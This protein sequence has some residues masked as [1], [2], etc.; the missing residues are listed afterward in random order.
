MNC[1]IVDDDELSRSIVEDLVK[2]TDSLN[3]L[4]SCEKRRRSLQC[5]ER[6]AQLIWCF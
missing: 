6:N 4:K 5:G 1:I 2:E 3:L